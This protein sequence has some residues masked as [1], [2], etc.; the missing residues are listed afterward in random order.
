MKSFARYFH[1]CYVFLWFATVGLCQPSASLLCFVLH[2][3]KW[4]II[5][6]SAPSN[7]PSVGQ[8]SLKAR[9]VGVLERRISSYE[10]HYHM[11][12]NHHQCTMTLI[13]CRKSTRNSSEADKVYKCCLKNMTG[14]ICRDGAIEIEKDET[15]TATLTCWQTGC[16]QNS[17]IGKTGRYHRKTTATLN[18]NRQD[19]LISES[20]LD[21]LT[22]KMIALNF[23]SLQSKN[24]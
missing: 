12:D 9:I 18:I 20:F 10:C 16:P 5:V 14:T 23:V 2:F 4:F 1:G 24:N 19:I 11:N 22:Q 13:G 6:F 3:F 17:K 8:C 21:L 7:S 15:S